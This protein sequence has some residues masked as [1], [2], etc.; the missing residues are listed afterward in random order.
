[1][2]FDAD[3][4]LGVVNLVFGDFG[5]FDDLACCYSLHKKEKTRKVWWISINGK[6]AKKIK[7]KQE[8]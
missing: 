6:M 4:W 7:E 3:L 2:E 1:L 5:H 8:K